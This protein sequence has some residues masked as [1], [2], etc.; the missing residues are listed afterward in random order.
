M[1]REGRL[2][3]RL[4]AKLISIHPPKAGTPHFASQQNAAAN[5]A[6]PASGLRGGTPLTHSSQSTLVGTGIVTDTI[7][8]S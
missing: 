5:F 2:G 3:A 6:G 8:V 1:G 4:S 7:R